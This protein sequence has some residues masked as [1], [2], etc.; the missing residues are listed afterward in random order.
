[1]EFDVSPMEL[2]KDGDSAEWVSAG[3]V[4]VSILRECVNGD[5]VAANKLFS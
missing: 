2:T 4:A 1:M 5:A 3:K